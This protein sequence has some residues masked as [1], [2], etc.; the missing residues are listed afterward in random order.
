MKLRV[1]G[2]SEQERLAPAKGNFGFSSI[3][4]HGDG[5]LGCLKIFGIERERP[6]ERGECAIQLVHRVVARGEQEPGAGIAG[7]APT[8]GFEESCRFPEPA[9]LEQAYRFRMRFGHESG[10]AGFTRSEGKSPDFPQ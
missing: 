1:V 6:F 7:I 2:V 8:G 4:Q 10:R 5:G 9:C 3:A